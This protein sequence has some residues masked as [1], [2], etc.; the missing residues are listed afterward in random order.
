MEKRDRGNKGY[1]FPERREG[2]GH[3]R[4]LVTYRGVTF[5]SAAP[6]S[7]TSPLSPDSPSIDELRLFYLLLN[8][9][10][11]QRVLIGSINRA[12][13]LSIMSD[14]A[15]AFVVVHPDSNVLRPRSERACRRTTAVLFLSELECNHLI[16]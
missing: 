16:H 6:P 11:N 13:Y 9:S 15:V 3:A 12:P 14:V 1:T 8:R 5:P 2:K 7:A 4:E 10:G